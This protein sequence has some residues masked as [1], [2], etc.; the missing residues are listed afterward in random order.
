MSDCVA[1]SQGV[2]RVCLMVASFINKDN[3]EHS[4]VTEESSEQ[5]NNPTNYISTNQSPDLISMLDALTKR[6]RSDEYEPDTCV[7]KLI[8]KRYDLLNRSFRNTK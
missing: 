7:K 6:A 3:L 2:Q 8:K 5:A 4:N 1:S